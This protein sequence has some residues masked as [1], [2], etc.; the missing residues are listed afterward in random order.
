MLK[1][2]EEDMMME[3]EELTDDE[4]REE[5]RE[6]ED[7]LL[8]RLLAAADYAANETMTL[9][10]RRPDKNNP[11]KMVKYFSF[12]VHPLSE[13]DLTKIRKK[14]TKYTR[15][16]RGGQKVV[17]EIDLVKFKCSVIY[18]STVEKDQE[19]IWNNKKLW[20]GLEKQGHVI[21]NALDVIEAVL[22]PGE[23]EKIMDAL[24]KLGGYDEDNQITEAKN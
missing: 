11:E 5:I 6:N 8:D 12:D 24:D 23:K 16:R 14:Y 15:N 13:D 1:D 2:Y 7:S 4:K 18:N 10:I 19:R 22:L 20:K 17:E 9:E 3:E 21:V